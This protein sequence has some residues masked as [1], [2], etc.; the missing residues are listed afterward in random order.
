LL[1]TQG[2]FKI[3]VVPEENEKRVLTGLPQLFSLGIGL[4][5]KSAHDQSTWSALM[6]V[7]SMFCVCPTPE[8]PVVS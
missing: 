2:R 5:H 1:S 6:S 8:C 4:V 3:F 7:A